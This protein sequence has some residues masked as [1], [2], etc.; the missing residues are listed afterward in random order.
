MTQKIKRGVSLYSFQ[1]ETYLGKMSL[2][3]AIGHCAAFGARGIEVVGEQ[4]FAG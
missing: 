1:N 2:D 4:T 3:Q